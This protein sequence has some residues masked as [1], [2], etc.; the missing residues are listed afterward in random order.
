MRRTLDLRT[1]ERRDVLPGEREGA[2]EVQH[3]EGRLALSRAE[4]RLRDG[5]VDI[6]LL[7]R[8]R[9]RHDDDHRAGHHDDDGAGD[10]HDDPHHEHDDQHDGAADHDDDWTGDDYDDSHHE[11]DDQHDGAADHDDDWTGD[12]HDD[13]HYDHDQHDRAADDDH[14]RADHDDDDSHHDHDE[15]D[16]AADDHD[17]S[18]DDDHHEHHHDS[19]HDDDQQHDDDHVLVALV[20]GLA[21]DDELRL[22]G[23]DRRGV[24]ADLRRPLLQHGLHDRGP[25]GATRSRLPLLRRRR[26]DERPRRGDPRRLDVGPPH[27]RLES[28]GREHRRPRHVH[29]RRRSGDTLHQQQLDARVHERRKLRRRRDV[30]RG[31]CEL[32]LRPA[33]SDPDPAAERRAHH[34]RAERR[35]RPEPGGAVG[36]QRD[37][38]HQHGRFLGV[39]AA[40]VAG[41]HHR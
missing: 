35:G 8:V 25:D 13:S 22:R 32:L 6:E 28:L 2:D 3:K 38:Q 27:H 21:G 31:R 19:H 10:D 26:C 9:R 15:H 36:C 5:R 14:D 11:H 7:R 39:D 29:D 37:D 23:S 33:A 1:V 20:H 4:R 16:G 12:D 18:H 40:R 17:D 30:V 34:L 24:R 41:L